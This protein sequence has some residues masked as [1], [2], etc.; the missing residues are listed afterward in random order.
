V[1]AVEIVEAG[2][3]EDERV[4]AVYNAVESRTVDLPLLRHRLG[5]GRVGRQ[6]L[7]RLA[8]SDVGVGYVRPSPAAADRPYAFAGV[9][10]VREARSQG[11]GGALYA[12][13]RSGRAAP[14]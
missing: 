14:A 7:A 3:D 5:P 13:V 12:A 9:H 1:T 6:V 10:V 4:L 2:P 8:G 11:A